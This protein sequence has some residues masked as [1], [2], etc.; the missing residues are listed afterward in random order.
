MLPGDGSDAAEERVAKES[1]SSRAR[2]FMTIAI[3]NR[4]SN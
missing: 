1:A 2:A 3:P 4:D